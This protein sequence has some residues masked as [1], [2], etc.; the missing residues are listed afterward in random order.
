M[1]N[2]TSIAV[3]I[4]I[5]SRFNRGGIRSLAGEDCKRGTPKQCFGK[6]RGGS[7]LVRRGTRQ[8]SGGGRLLPEASDVHPKG[9]YQDPSGLADLYLLLLLYC[10]Q[11]SP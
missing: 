4:V 10:S 11:I 7:V 5:E 1:S 3:C 9:E 6:K 8:A 2:D